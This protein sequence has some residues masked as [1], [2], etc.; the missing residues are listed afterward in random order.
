[1]NTRRW[2]SVPKGASV[3]SLSS[4]Q[5]HQYQYWH[6]LQYGTFH[7]NPLLLLHILRMFQTL[8]AELNSKFARCMVD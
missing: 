8:N 1:M 7:M 4:Q 6:P 2:M 5:W 3:Y